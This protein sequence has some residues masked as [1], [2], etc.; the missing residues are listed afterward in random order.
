VVSLA[1]GRR[2]G[3]YRHGPNR[4]LPRHLGKPA[5]SPRALPTIGNASRLAR[6]D[7]CFRLSESPVARLAECWFARP[8]AVRGGSRSRCR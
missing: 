7:C 8:P 3:G 6:T 4:R 5:L 2:L 1:C